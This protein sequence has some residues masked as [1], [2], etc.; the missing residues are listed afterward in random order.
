M[1]IILNRENVTQFLE[2]K[3]SFL[4]KIYTKSSIFK[5]EYY[6]LETIE[7]GIGKY[8]FLYEKSHDDNI[9]SL[10]SNDESN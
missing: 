5:N 3:G 9:I 1:K 8:R 10:G 7:N 2:T 6:E 4:P